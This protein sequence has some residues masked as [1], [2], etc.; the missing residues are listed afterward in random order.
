MTLAITK[1]DPRYIRRIQPQ[2]GIPQFKNPEARGLNSNRPASLTELADDVVAA[3]NAAKSSAKVDAKKIGILGSSQGGWVGSMVAAKS[4]DVSY[5][6]MRV[7]PGQNVLETIAHEYEGGFIAEGFSKEEIAEIM[8]MYRQHWA[9]AAK[10]KTWEDGNNVFL[11]YQNK[12]WY[13]KIYTEPR[14]K[15]EASA[16]WWT[17]LSKNLYVDS[18]DYLKQLKTTPVLWQLAEKDWNVNSQKSYPRLVEA[19]TKAGNKDFRVNILPNMGHS[20]LVVKTGLPN[21]E[22]SW[23][24]AAGFWD[25][26]A[27]WLKDRKIAK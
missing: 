6:L 16:K 3:V 8:Q 13:K 11:S 18:Y 26:M 25:T 12:P 10:N 4:K 15:S 2:F 20:G 1:N 24:Y 19:L 22:F 14:V 17:W 21:D 7:G 27:T 5:L 9:L 23:Q